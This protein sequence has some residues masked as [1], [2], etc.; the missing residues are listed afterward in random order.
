MIE[1]PDSLETRKNYL[2]ARSLYSFFRNVIP[3]IMFDFLREF[4]VF[5]KIKCVLRTRLCAAC[6][7]S[8]LVSFF[9]SFFLS[10]SIYFSIYFFIFK[11]SEM[12]Y[13]LFNE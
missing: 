3:E 13:N 8:S 4:D 1:C 9:L 7:K 11:S 10:F 12:F 5:Y 2:E 6:L